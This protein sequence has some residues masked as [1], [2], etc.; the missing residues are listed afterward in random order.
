MREVPFLSKASTDPKTRRRVWRITP[1]GQNGT[2]AYFTSSSFD[3]QGRLLASIEIKG[4]TQLCRVDLQHG[5]CHQLTDLDGLAFQGYCVLPKRNGAVMCRNGREIVLIDTETG[6]ARVVFTAP[7]GFVTGCPTG[8][9]SG[10]YLAFVVT[11]TIPTFTRATA[12]YST[13][14]ENFYARPRSL[15]CRLDLETDALDVVWGE[16][17]W[18]SHVLI[19]PVDPDTIVFCHEGGYM[20]DSRLWVVSARKAHKKQPRCLFPETRN[21]FLVH[22]FFCPDGV[23]GVQIS[24]WPEDHV[25]MPWGDPRS[26]HGVLFLDMD[27]GIVTEY[28]HTADR[29]MHVQASNDRT[30]IVAD[31]LSVAW[32][33]PQ[34]DQSLSLLRPDA[35]KV[36]RPE[37]LCHHG[38][39]WKT[40]HSHPHP[41]FSPDGRCVAFTSDTGGSLSPYVVELEG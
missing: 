10:R 9:N 2:H 36:L 23:L 11:E 35:A 17:R 20:P 25:E 34:D 4:S 38:S 22:E 21:H 27:G 41:S 37:P 33:Q 13:M 6:A 3:I 16:Q 40:Q 8:D 19:N 14:E 1:P 32:D 31:T 7:E 18:L 26:R 5:T 28:A 15:I 24:A 12:I 29:S 39:S 30:L